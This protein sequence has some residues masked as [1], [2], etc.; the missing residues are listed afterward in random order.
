[1]I[2]DFL[3]LNGVKYEYERPYAHDVADADHSQYRPDFYYPDVDVWHEHWALD[4]DG[5]PP[6]EFDGYAGVDGVEEVDAPPARHDPDRDDV[7]RDH[8]PERVRNPWPTTSRRT[9]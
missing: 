4:R 7:G 2:A 8:R 1:M 3:F 9:G 6:A 5:N